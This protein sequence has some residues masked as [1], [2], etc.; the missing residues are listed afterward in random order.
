MSNIKTP[1]KNPNFNQNQLIVVFKEDE[2]REACDCF[3]KEI[4]DNV[5][6]IH[7]EFGDIKIERI[8]DP[9]FKNVELWKHQRIDVVGSMEREIAGQDRT[10]VDFIIY[11][12]ENG[13]PEIIDIE[14]LEGLTNF[15]K[16]DIDPSQLN[17]D[18]EVIIAVLDTGVNTSVIPEQYLWQ[19]EE[20]G[21]LINGVNF[22]VDQISEDGNNYERFD[23]EDDNNV[24]H[25]TLVNAFIIEQ[26]R[27]SGTKVKIMNLKTHNEKGVGNLF[28]A[29][30]AIRFAIEKGAHIINASWGFYRQDYE[31]LE[32]LKDLITNSLK[33]KGVLF[34]A[35]SGNAFKVDDDKFLNDFP[36]RK[37]EDRNPRDLSQ[38]HFYPAFFGNRIEDESK[39]MF[40][41]TTVKNDSKSFKISP[42]QNFSPNVVD[43]GIKA[44]GLY[45]SEDEEI[46][47][48]KFQIPLKKASDEGEAFVFGSSFAAAI[49]TGKIGSNF[50]SEFLSKDRVE[51]INKK[52]FL[53]S[54]LGLDFFRKD[55]RLED[56]IKHGLYV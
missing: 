7:P 19:G 38:H 1:S 8:Q 53:E 41:V 42:R 14:H 25:G 30:S 46:E 23:I 11:N 48:F 12:H 21:F 43:L 22:L 32:P 28:T 17:G 36:S 33:N 45:I 4:E 44:D 3:L 52:H 40:V 16:I 55:P 9:V 35:A 51:K 29:I 34:V 54:D 10:N 13:I 5:K 24:S 26:F 49:A 15:E 27:G 2:D 50:A 31:S 37:G 18:K 39:Y 20:N 6:K 56:W 47:D